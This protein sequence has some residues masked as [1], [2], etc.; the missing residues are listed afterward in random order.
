MSEICGVLGQQFSQF[1]LNFVLQIPFF[2]VFLRAWNRI[3]Q[4]LDL[5]QIR[6]LF[7]FWQATWKLGQSRVVRDNSTWLKNNYIIV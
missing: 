7:D 5:P 4:A 2:A 1:S 6:I 3:I